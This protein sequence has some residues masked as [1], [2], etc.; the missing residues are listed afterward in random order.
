VNINSFLQ[1]VNTNGIATGSSLQG[2]YTF[3]SGDS[4]LI[5]NN[6]YNT[7]FMYYSGIVSTLYTPLINL[8]APITNSYFSGVHNFR[9][10]YSTANDFGLLLDV[11][12]DS[13]SKRNLVDYCL[14]S[15]NT[16]ATGKNFGLFINDANRLSFRTNSG[17]YS[18]LDKELTAHDFVYFSL[19]QHQYVTFGV[20]NVA[21]NF[22]YNQKIDLG[23]PILNSDILCIGSEFNNANSTGFFGT[24]SNAILFNQAPEILDG[25]ISCY[26]TSGYN[27]ISTTTSV[28]VPK[29]T[30]VYYSGIQS[31]LVY[32]S[33]N[34]GV[35]TKQNGSTVNVEYSTS[36]STGIITGQV[37]TL[38][39]SQTGVNITQSYY[40]FYKD[41]GIVNS[42]NRY[43]INFTYPVQ[44]G[45]ALEIYTYYYPIPNLGTRIIGYDI[46]N[47]GGIMQLI[48]NGV[49]ETLNV[50]YTIIRNQVSGFFDNDILAYDS[51]NSQSIIL[52]FSGTFNNNLTGLNTGSNPYLNVTGLSGVCYSNIN[53][54][55]FGYDVFL[56]GQKLISGYEYTVVNSGVSG[57]AVVISGDQIMNPD[58]SAIDNAELGF[59]PQFNNFIYFLS[60]VTQPTYTLSG[61]VGFSEQIWTN[62]IRQIKGVDYGITFPCF[63]QDNSSNLVNFPYL[64]Y[65]ND[66]NW[67]FQ[68]PPSIINLSGYITGNGNLTG[69]YSWNT[70][71]LNNYNSG[72]YLEFCGKSGNNDYNT[73]TYLDV[74]A[75]GFQWNIGQTGH[76]NYCAQI[77]YRNNN[78]M[79]EISQYCINY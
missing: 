22:F 1:C 12:Y 11:Q 8:G 49:D 53:Y 32:T 67:N 72:Q 47:A 64:F 20:Y 65:N 44:S 28:N 52:N 4:N 30:G 59:I 71:I 6:L 48:N 58:S 13:C 43:A 79:G 3:N 46:S 37:A 75:S 51:L 54:P 38:L 16:F 23:G 25:C 18:T 2:I 63:T 61:I 40:Q 27:L 76:D 24:I 68:Y 77:R 7:G 50:D 55:K 10:G 15:S 66:G 62:G 29:I 19:S 14:L 26:F 17:Y 56:N 35:I 21:D 39:Y 74:G 36:L 73:I 69:F 78:I 60:G 57:F 70:I 42:Y 31:T 41:T 45:D 34:S 5:Y 9:V 33:L